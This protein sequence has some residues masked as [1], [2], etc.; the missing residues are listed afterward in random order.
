MRHPCSA[1]T[2]RGIVRGWTEG[3]EV[4]LE[5]PQKRRR[6]SADQNAISQ[7]NVKITASVAR[8][9]KAARMSFESIFMPGRYQKGRP[10]YKGKR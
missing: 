5:Q 3:L 1:S 6:G 10:E 8:S 7:I 2:S 4:A 9:L